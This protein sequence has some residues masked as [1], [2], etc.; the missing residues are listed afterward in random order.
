M[1]FPTKEYW[2]GLPF[3][4]L[5]DLPYSGIE[6]PSPELAVEFFTT[7]PPGEPFGAGETL[8]VAQGN[9]SS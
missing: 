4:S 9:Q 6:P 2:S 1:G 7:E 5:E 3:P 8:T